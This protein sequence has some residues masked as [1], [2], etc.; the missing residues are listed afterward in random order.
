MLSC[1]DLALGS[2]ASHRS[3]RNAAMHGLLHAWSSM[4]P[5]PLPP[6]L[7]TQTSAPSVNT[8]VKCS[9]KCIAW[10]RLVL[11]LN[12]ARLA[13]EAA[14]G[15]LAY[16]QVLPLLGRRRQMRVSFCE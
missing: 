13:A 9:K 3:W 16:A 4:P 5:P 8:S 1:G 6:L 2:S 14:G 10:V 15:R 7:A 11:R 12:H